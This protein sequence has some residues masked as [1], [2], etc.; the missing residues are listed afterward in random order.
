MSSGTRNDTTSSGSTNEH[1]HEL[2][3]EIT[4]V[5]PLATMMTPSAI[6]IAR[7]ILGELCWCKGLK[8]FQTTEEQVSCAAPAPAPD[9]KNRISLELF[10]LYTRQTRFRALIHS[11]LVQR[12]FQVSSEI[13]RCSLSWS[14][15]CISHTACPSERRFFTGCGVPRA[16]FLLPASMF[17]SLSELHCLRALIKDFEF[18]FTFLGSKD[19]QCQSS[20]YEIV[21]HHEE[22]HFL[23]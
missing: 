2:G 14:A 13:S 9:E 10:C 18:S 7:F 3:W 11:I 17:D 21:R 22:Y 19:Q 5:A 20:N 1:G 4:T 23:L 6:A 16:L 8:L 12:D 15:S